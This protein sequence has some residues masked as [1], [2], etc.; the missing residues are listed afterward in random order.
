[1]I[2]KSYQGV[3]GYDDQSTFAVVIDGPD[4]SESD[5]DTIS[6]SYS[7][8]YGNKPEVQ[9]IDGLTQADLP[10]TVV[11]DG[12]TAGLLYTVYARALS[13]GLQSTQ[14]AKTQDLGKQSVHICDP[15]P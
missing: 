4:P 8:P 9:E 13:G 14:T 1:M 12:L 6:V 11:L 3:I 15:L 10:I 2:I 5:F 7:P